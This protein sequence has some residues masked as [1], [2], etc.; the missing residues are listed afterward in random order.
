MHLDAIGPKEVETYEA[1]KL[2]EG[3]SPKSI[4][5]H[6]TVLRRGLALAVEWGKL[7]TVTTIRWL[8]V[9]EQPF[10][11]LDFEEAGRLVDAADSPLWRTMIVV[12]L[13]T[14]LR[15]GELLAL[16]WEDVDLVGGRLLVRRGVV[17]GIVGTPKNGRSSRGRGAPGAQGIPSPARKTRFL[18]RRRPH[19]DQG[20]M[21]APGLAPTGQVSP[22]RF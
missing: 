6:L 3:L 14:G 20:R 7:P 17:D 11:F 13:W 18:R 8:R 15:Q 1:R 10:D 19:A 22:M 12:G 16:R 2:A 21:Q 5:N 9:P 4:N